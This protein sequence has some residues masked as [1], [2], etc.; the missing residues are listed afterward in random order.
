MVLQLQLPSEGL[1][2]Y[3]YLWSTGADTE[4]ISG[5]AAGTYE[6]TVTDSNLCEDDI[7]FTIIDPVE[8]CLDR[9]FLI[10]VQLDQ[11]PE[12]VSYEI[13]D[14]EGNIVASM[15][16]VGYSNGAYFTDVICLPDDCYTLTVSDSFGDGLC[17]SYS[18]SSGL[19]NI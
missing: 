14:D 9:S 6:L 5:L 18:T 16:F 8:E 4:S 3:S 1:A 10:E 11:Y 7:M 17:A 13:S 12:Q 2:P 15:S 19:H